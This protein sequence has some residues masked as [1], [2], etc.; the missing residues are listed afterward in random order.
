MYLSILALVVFFYFFDKVFN[1]RNLYNPLV[2]LVIYHFV[3][4]YLGIFYSDIYSHITIDDSS[5]N[6]IKYSFFS[7]FIGGI[8]SRLLFQNIGLRYQRIPEVKFHISYNN[9]HIV[10]AV[11]FI[12]I[13]IVLTLNFNISNGG[14]IFFMDEI[15][16][17]RIKLRK[18]RGLLTQLIIY[19]ITYGLLAYFM[20]R[21]RKQSVNIIVLII[22]CFCVL[23][24]GNRGPVLFLLLHVFLVYQIVYSRQ[25]S[26]KK[27]F[28]YFSI[29]FVF[30][31]MMGAYRVN[32]SADF[33]D[34]FKFRL[35]WRPFVNIQ[36]FQMVLDHF[37]TKHE[38]LWGKTYLIDLSILLPGSNPNSGT[39]LKE[40][41]GLSFDG[42]SI[43][44][45][46]LGISYVNFGYAGMIL[47]PIILGFIANSFYEVYLKT[48]NLAN[49]HALILLILVSNNFAAIVVSGIM[50][51]LIQNM[52][53]ILLI[54]FLYVFFIHIFK[55]STFHKPPQ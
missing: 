49:P 33:I 47:S 4:F 19:F 16:N 50:T 7:I 55:T 38:F 5:K 36:N 8:I 18:G 53:I 40:L 42:G 22:C 37:P 48:L 46:Y 6:W 35:A 45:S 32:H 21:K 12:L 2:F 3:F 54:H 27:V 17:S 25:F 41:M 24:L 34:L 1:L 52:V 28:L 15:E 29:L 44:P 11:I 30:M 10:L 51:V 31:V 20:Q 23:T 9:I 43:T 39:F 26:Y 13:G 14:I